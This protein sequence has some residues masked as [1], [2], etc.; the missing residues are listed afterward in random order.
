MSDPSVDVQP[1]S[2][3][4]SAEV[5]GDPECLNDDVEKSLGE[6]RELIFGQEV[7]VR[8]DHRLSSFRADAQN[9][10]D[11]LPEAI[12][13]APPTSLVS[14]ARST[15]ENAIKESVNLEQEILAD[16]LFPIIGPATR[17]AVTTAIK[18]LADSLNQG[19]ELSVSPQSVGW[20]FEAWRTG[21]PFA[22][23]VLLR[24]LLY[25]V[26]QVLLIH[27][28]TGLMLHDVVEKKAPDQDP[29]LVSSMLTA[30]EDFVRD[31]FSTKS[32]SF[33]D[34]VEFGELTLLIEDGPQAVLA[35]V[36]RGVAPTNL[37]SLM[38][39]TLEKIHR[40]YDA[41]LES[42]S[43]DRTPFD[44]TETYLQECLLFQSR[45]REKKRSPLV[46]ISSVC[47]L[48]LLLFIARATY[49]HFQWRSA[50]G[51]LEREPGITLLRE[52][53]G[54][55]VGLVKGLLKG[56]RDP[57][58]PD[59]RDLLEESGITP[60]DVKF[61]FEPYW[62]LSP[63]LIEK[64]ARQRLS[65][66]ADINLTYDPATL[67]LSAKGKA[68]SAWI[69]SINQ[70]A[71]NQPRVNRVDTS[72][73]ELT[74]LAQLQS[75]KQIIEKTTL[76]FPEGS[77]TLEPQSLEG[78]KALSIS[79]QDITQLALKIRQPVVIYVLGQASPP[80]PDENNVRLSQLRADLIV[81]KLIQSGIPSEFLRAEGIGVTSTV[82][83]VEVRKAQVSFRVEIDQP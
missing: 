36:I 46:W 1:E 74:E 59:P 55:T 73:V 61:E 31:S 24:T 81:R 7:D 77:V 68:S 72:Q 17:K 40:Q 25:R 49:L 50:I 78:L 23:V 21:R 4:V 51:K 35:C 41:K 34:S 28:E 76:G 29:E 20:R 11:I 39:E 79:V 43:G 62:S 48:G 13:L 8:V 10:A 70:F 15:V 83:N 30:I 26:E 67:I 54:W 12:E 63:N 47:L 14:S 64:T 80:G 65:A 5:E 32:D 69:E 45:P 53:R 52:R 27:K 66:P 71:E 60:D 37:R 75:L 19:I 82:D 58:A 44:T 42:F 16:A 57:L 9:I 22:E 33:L 3:E 18:T 38:Q 56:L 6:L 2:L